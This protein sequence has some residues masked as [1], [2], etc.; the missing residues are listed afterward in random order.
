MNLPAS[1]SCEQVGKIIRG[2]PVG[3]LQAPRPRFDPVAIVGTSENCRYIP[4]VDR[5]QELPARAEDQRRV[6]AR[7]PGRQRKPRTS[8]AYTSVVLTITCSSPLP[9]ISSSA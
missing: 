9:R 3:T 2:D 7:Q 4:Y 1:S 8:R 6:P 5:R